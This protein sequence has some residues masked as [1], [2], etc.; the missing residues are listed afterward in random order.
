MKYTIIRLIVLTLTMASP[1]TY[2][3][4]GE[5]TGLIKQIDVTGGEDYGFRVQL[6]GG[7][8]LCANAHTW[9]YLNASDSNYN[10]YVSVLLAARMA[11]KTVTIYTDNWSCLPK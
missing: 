2:S 5:V 1:L 8:S 9:A 4:D 11:Q 7:P 6:E 10:A 3:W